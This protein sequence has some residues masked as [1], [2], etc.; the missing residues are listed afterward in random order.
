M[1]NNEIFLNISK[2]VFNIYT[3]VRRVQE[4]LIK[5]VYSF[6]PY[7]I[8]SIDFISD[9]NYEV[10]NIYKHKK[11]TEWISTKFS[12][13]LSGYLRIHYWDINKQKLTDMILHTKHIIKGLKS[14]D[15][16]TMWAYSHEGIIKLLLDYIKQNKKIEILEM[17]INKQSIYKSHKYII[18]S[19]SISENMT[20]NSLV[21]FYMPELFI[22]EDDIIF[23]YY[24]DNLDEITIVNNNFIS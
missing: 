8:E 11:M 19:L 1:L 15:I 9:N 10:K 13:E 16:T 4:S 17:S 22:K 12:N 18:P 21:A 5:W 24:N 14:T 20:P 2:N 7:Y 3:K 23:I 6:I